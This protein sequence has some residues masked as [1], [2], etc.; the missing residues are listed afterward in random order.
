[1]PAHAKRVLRSDL[2]QNFR[3]GPVLE[4]D[5]L[6]ADAAN[7]VIVLRIPVIVLVDFAPVG[8]GDSSQEA[9]FHHQPQSAVHRRPAD[10]HTAFPLHEPRRQLIS[11]EMEV[12]GHTVKVL[13]LEDLIRSKRAAGRPKDLAVLPVL[14][15]TLQMLKEKTDS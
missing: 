11:V 6:S 13:A 12:A 5:E 1:M 9:G 4:L 15:A 14:E 3:D 8:P 2:V 10:T 7:E